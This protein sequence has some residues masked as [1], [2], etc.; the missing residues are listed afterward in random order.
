MEQK[1]IYA[2][3]FH[4]PHIPWLLQSK[5]M[6]HEKKKNYFHCRP[7]L[8]HTWIMDKMDFGFLQPLLMN[9]QII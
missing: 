8:D 7:D 4:L 2:K 6:K 1:N 3:W 9:L 5:R